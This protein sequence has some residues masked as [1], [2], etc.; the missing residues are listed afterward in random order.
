MPTKAKLQKCANYNRCRRLAKGPY[1]KFCSQ[2]FRTNAAM[3]GR[4]TSGNT[5][6]M[7]KLGNIGNCHAH[8]RRWNKGNVDAKGNRGNVGNAHA[9]GNLENAGN[10]HGNPGNTGN[11]DAKGNLENAGNDHG[12]P[13]N[14]GSV[15]AKGNLENAGN[16]HG[17]PGNSGN[18]VI[19]VSKKGAGARSGV[20]RSAKKALVVKKKWLDLILAG[21]KTWEIRGRSTA[22]RGW[23]HFAESQAGG[24]LMGRARLV[25]CFP[26]PKKDFKRHFK[27]H[28]VPELSMVPYT[29]PHAWVFEDVEKFQKPFE[30][31]HTQGA[32]VWVDV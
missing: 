11:V 32:V 2:C 26:V 8:G 12:N 6:A 20:R 9:H 4:L 5:R 7:G 19:G 15:D 17:N 29:T 22:K 24:K 3:H 23:I 13:G 28:L 21:K 10:A 14:T 27:K 25:N 30:Y 18:V 16:A 1:A 31:E